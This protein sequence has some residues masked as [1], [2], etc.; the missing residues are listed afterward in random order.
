MKLFQWGGKNVTFSARGGGFSAPCTTLL[1]L[2]KDQRFCYGCIGELKEFLDV[3]DS[4]EEPCEYSFC[5]FDGLFY[6]TFGESSS[7]KLS[8]KKAFYGSGLREIHI[9]DIVEEL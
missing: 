4:I 6:V 7:L 2:S 3:P 5:D 1:L 8:G 9:P